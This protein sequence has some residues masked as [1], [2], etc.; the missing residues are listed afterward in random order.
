MEDT[1]QCTALNFLQS[2]SKRERK[3]GENVRENQW[4]VSKKAK[5]LQRI[6]DGM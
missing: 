6:E 3:T 5:G 2:H 4:Y 1:L